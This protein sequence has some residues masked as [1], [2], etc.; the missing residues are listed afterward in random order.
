MRGPKRGFSG[1][2]GEIARKLHL[3]R[4][5]TKLISVD[6]PNTT[7]D[8][9]PGSQRRKKRRLTQSKDLSSESLWV[10]I[11]ESLDIL[12]RAQENH[13]C[14]TTTIVGKMEAQNRKL[15]A[16][17]LE[18]LDFQTRRLLEETFKDTENQVRT[19]VAD[20]VEGMWAQ[21]R[22]V[23]GIKLRIQQYGQKE[24]RVVDHGSSSNGEP[25]ST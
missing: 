19:L 17:S 4:G 3:P 9:K 1:S 12:S 14:I 11:G 5:S 24:E 21:Q 8:E 18:L 20:L 10:S 23:I 25:E 16:E 13:Q 2:S 22:R 7:S 15:I 6:S